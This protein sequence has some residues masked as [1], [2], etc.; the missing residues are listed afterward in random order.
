M[1]ETNAVKLLVENRVGNYSES[2]RGAIYS[3]TS[4]TVPVL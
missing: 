4:V 3:R 2:A 1:V